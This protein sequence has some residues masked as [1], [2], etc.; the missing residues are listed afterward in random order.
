VKSKKKWKRRNYKRVQAKE[1]YVGG[2]DIPTD[3]EEIVPTGQ[4][5]R[6][7]K[8]AEEKNVKNLQKLKK[9]TGTLQ[10]FPTNLKSR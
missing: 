5:H 3:L 6:R 4:K 7:S 1:E 8:K 9:K 2:G 10:M